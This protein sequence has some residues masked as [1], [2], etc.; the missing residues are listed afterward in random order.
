MNETLEEILKQHAEKY[1]KMQPQDC[2]K[3]LY[4]REFM[5]DHLIQD[6]IHALLML[7][8]E[9]AKTAADPDGELFV[10]I[11]GCLCRLNLARAKTRYTAEQVNDWFVRTASCRNG[12]FSEYF[13]A[14]KLLKK[15]AGLFA[16]SQED[17]D[18][19]FA[20]YRS[21]GYPAVHHSPEYREAYDPHYRVILQSFLNE[22]Q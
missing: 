16:F 13:D 9:W 14:L 3:L 11:G 6:P 8:S 17:L 12:S 21:E 1:P 4:Q 2:V 19:Y 10:P 15:N 18:N 20:Y 5:G 7:K 22:E